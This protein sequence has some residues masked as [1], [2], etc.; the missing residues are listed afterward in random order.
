MGLSWCNFCQGERLVESR[1]Y[2]HTDVCPIEV[3]AILKPLQ[4]PGDAGVLT[5]EDMR[6][7]LGVLFGSCDK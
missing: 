4:R 3:L 2:D 6:Y 5:S 1:D 7:A